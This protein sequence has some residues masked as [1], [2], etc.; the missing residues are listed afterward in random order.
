MFVLQ[1]VKKFYRVAPMLKAL[2]F[3]SAI[4]CCQFASAQSEEALLEQ[5][6]TNIT[7]LT[8]VLVTQH[9]KGNEAFIQQVDPAN[10]NG[11]ETLQA[12]KENLIDI[13][14]AGYYNV[15]TITQQGSNNLYDAD[16][17]GDNVRIDIKQ[18][19][20]ENI[21]SQSL[22]LYNTGF[23]I[24]QNGDGNEIIQTGSASNSMGIQ[25]QQHGSGMRLVIQSN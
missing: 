1:I 7:P 18:H 17:E 19:G 2:M 22:F 9:G 24:I 5:M 21:I 13:S 25:I 16:I 23:S 20:H 4:A 11:I 12:G 15:I 6:Q 3:L 14:Q 8:E 10:S